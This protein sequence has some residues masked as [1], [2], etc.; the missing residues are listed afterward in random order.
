MRC[1]IS[2]SAGQVL[3]SGHLFVF[4]DE[5]TGELR[6]GLR[7]DGG[8]LIYGGAIASDGSLTDA[9]KELFRQISQ[10]LRVSGFTLT[11]QSS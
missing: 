4:E 11:V 3:A 5:E 1:A 8:R 10:T 2:S 9:S 6:L 7:T